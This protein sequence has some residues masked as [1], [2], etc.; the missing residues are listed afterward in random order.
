MIVASSC[1]RGRIPVKRF[2]LMISVS[3]VGCTRS[4]VVTLDDAR[5]RFEQSSAVYQTCMNAIGG[6]HTCISERLIM[7]AD[8]KAYTEAM[9][10]GL[11]NQN[12]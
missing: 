3:L 4:P 11:G 2:V 5:N 12:R 9:S 6:D 8:Q 7:E 10:G 1:S